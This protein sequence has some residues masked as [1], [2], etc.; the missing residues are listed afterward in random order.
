MLRRCWRRRSRGGTVG[1]GIDRAIAPRARARLRRGARRRPR[2]CTRAVARAM[3]PRDPGRR[4]RRHRRRTG[5]T[6][7][8]RGRGPRL[9]RRALWVR[10]ADSPHLADASGSVQSVLTAGACGLAAL[11]LTLAGRPLVGGT[12]HAIAQASRGSQAALTPIARLVGEPDFGPLTA[13]VIGTGEGRPVRDRTVNRS[14][15]AYLGAALNVEVARVSAGHQHLTE[16]SPAAEDFC[17]RDRRCFRTGG[18]RWKRSRPRSSTGIRKSGSRPNSHTEFI[19][20]TE[21]LEELLAD[22]GVDDWSPER[23]EP[24]HDG[25]HR[26]ERARTA[27]P[28]GLRPASPEGRAGHSARTATTTRPFGP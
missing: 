15:G 24:S 22:S 11:A 25:G 7:H 14:H 19:D 20:L 6:R 23:P 17:A 18:H 9:R 21:S 3:E 4:E 5:G 13:A 28:G 26:R 2:R 1:R 27:A 8:R 16:C 12:I 10:K